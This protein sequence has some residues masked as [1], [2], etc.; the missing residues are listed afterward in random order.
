MCSSEKILKLYELFP[1]GMVVS[2][3]LILEIEVVTRLEL[4]T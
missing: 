2:L 1:T 3:V 4:E